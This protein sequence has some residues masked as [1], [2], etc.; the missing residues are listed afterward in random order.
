MMAGCPIR[1]QLTHKH[2]MIMM[3]PPWWVNGQRDIDGAGFDECCIRPLPMK[4]PRETDFA[5]QAVYRYLT[6]LIGEPASEDRVRLPS[7]RQL[8]ARL[9]VSISTIQYAYSLLEKEGRVYSVAKSGYY[10]FAVSTLNT[11]SSGNDLLETVYVNARRPG[12]LVLSADEPALLQPL[13][14]PLL[15]LERELLRQYP[16]QPQPASQ[17]CGELE[18]RAAL[19]ARY[20]TSPVRCWHADDVYIGADL[21]GVL[22]ILI[23]VLNLKDATMVVESPC[24]WAILRLLQAAGVR[25]LEL[26][27]EAN[28]GLD[29]ERLKEL[30]ESEPVRLVMLSSGLNMPRGSLAPDDNRQA[31]AQLLARHGSWVL[32]NDCYGELGFEPDSLRFRDL[33][34]PDRLLVF[35]TFEKIIGPEAP[36]GYLLSRHLR[37]EL[38][39]HFLLRSFRLSPIRQKAIARLYSSGRIDQH[40]Q[41]LRRL[42]KD[43]KVQ[44]TQLLQERLG[45]ALQFV[46]PQGGATI[47][48]RSLRQVDVRRVF[49][50]LLKHQVVIAP[51]E[52]FSLQ[53]LHTQHLRLSHTFA[54]DHDLSAALGLLGTALRLESID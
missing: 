22:E 19:A 29:L 35:S 11:F 32:E 43:R 30:L 45:D 46:E 9:G 38:Q 18:L 24:D 26:P 33:L 1:K 42:L 6:Q 51:G 23:A 49:Q 41:V 40:L 12:M 16:R 7:L 25:V 2:P 13:D 8:A 50:R 37:E 14:S 44:M 54:G 15:L 20:T 4:G 21:R 10:A 36:Y 34:N 52:L 3:M 17:P 5:Y 47:W 53:G 39:R 28:D 48:V 27:V 31:V